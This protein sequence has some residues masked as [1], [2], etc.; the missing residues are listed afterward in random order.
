MM[1][2]WAL[3]ALCAASPACNEDAPDGTGMIIETVEG[4][5]S[6]PELGVSLAIHARGGRG[7]FIHVE[8]GEFLALS[9]PG[10]SPVTQRF[11]C[12]A[13]PASSAPLRFTID[14]SVRPDADEALLF[15]A[16]Y[17]DDDCSGEVIQGRIL[18]VHP[19]LATPATIDA[20]T[21]AT[22]EGQP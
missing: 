13:N 21:S 10:T 17:A 3:I 12:F 11:A 4:Q 18:A 8:R 14:L 15:A 1:R 16:L 22:A 7:V 2:T 6:A 19:P 20:G 9:T 5:P